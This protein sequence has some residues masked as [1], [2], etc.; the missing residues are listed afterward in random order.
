MPETIRKVAVIGRLGLYP[1]VKL[2]LPARRLLAYVAVF[3]NP[4]GRAGAAAAL[5]PDVGDEQARANLRRALWQLP[6]GWIEVL[7]DD[8]VLDA[9]TDLAEA[10]M[11]A[12]QA[13]TGGT[14]ALPAIRMLSHDLLPGWYDEWVQPAQE[15]FRLLRV[16]ALETV[17]L[18]LAR[19]GQ[20]ALA[21]QAGFAALSAEPLR[22]SAAAALIEAHLAQGNRYDA[23]TCFRELGQRLMEEL[24]VEPDPALVARMEVFRLEPSRSEGAARTPSGSLASVDGAIRT[25]SR[26]VDHTIRHD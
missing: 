4:V 18:T 14:L 7:G 16:Q 9:R 15:S 23:A 24:G 12:D 1:L 10:Q 21:T 20:A 5:W 13:I 17:C 8:L 25:E 22:E 3:G 26:R 6:R 11:V 19:A 2:S